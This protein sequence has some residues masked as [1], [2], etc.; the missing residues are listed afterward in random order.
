MSGSARVL[1]LPV[2]L[3]VV[4]LLAAL[5][6]G[7]WF[8]DRNDEHVAE[9]FDAV[10]ETVT[11]SLNERL[12]LYDYG[13]RGL[14]GAI[15]TAGPEIS[16]A[17]FE[18]YAATRDIPAEFPGVLGFGFV[19]RVLPDEMG[20]FIDAARAEGRPDFRVAQLL[21]HDGERFVI[22]YIEPLAGNATAI[23]LDIASENR[24]RQ[25][26]LTAM[27]TGKATLTPP[28]TLLQQGGMVPGFLLLLPVYRPGMATATPDQ[29]RQA[30]IGWAYAPLMID[31]VLADLA[32]VDPDIAFGIRDM[33]GDA[34]LPPFVTTAGFLTADGD[35]D[36]SPRVRRQIA[37][38]AFGRDWVLDIHPRPQF[39]DRLNLTKP[40]WAAGRA[41]VLGTLL[42]VLLYLHLVHLRRRER[43]AAEIR[44]LAESL[45]RQVAERTA[46]L[47]QREARFKALTELSADWYW[48]VNEAGRF[49]AISHGVMKLGLDPA[50]LIG[51]S[52]RDLAVD[53]DDPAID[54]YEAVLA[55]RLPFRDLAYDLADGAGESR[56]I[57][58][59]GE[60][61]FTED[62]IF[63]GFRG[64]GRDVTAEVDAKAALAAR[65]ALL[66]AVF[67]TVDQGIAVFGPDRRLLA[68]NARLAVLSTVPSELLTQ[69]IHLHD[70]LRRNARRGAYGPGDPDALVH[71]LIDGL[72]LDQPF[73]MERARA[74]GSVVDIRA[75]PMER[76]GFIATYADV[77]EARR[78][79]RDVTQA[80]DLLVSIMDVSLN[81]IVAFDAMRDAEGTIQDFRLVLMNRAAGDLIGVSADAIIGRCLVEA[82]PGFARRELFDRYRAV[83]ETGQPALF[84][85]HHD[86]DGRSLWL[87]VQA[88]PRAG[89]L[90][91]TFSD[92]TP[93]RE[94]EALLRASEARLQAIVGTIGI[95]VVVTAEDGRVS[96]VNRAA[97]Q[98]LGW[99]PGQLVG[100]DLGQMIR[101]APD[102]GPGAFSRFIRDTA[103]G[104]GS[105]TGEVTAIRRDGLALAVEMSVSAFMAGVEVMYVA[106]LADLSERNKAVVD[107]RQVNQQLE[108]QAAEL[109]ILA[110]E[111][112]RAR[113]VAETA[114]RA[115]SE[116]L[117][118]MSHEI[119]TPM[120][121][122]MGMTQILLG[123]P[124]TPDQRG[125][126]E[127]VR[128][129]AEALLGVIDDI[130]DVTKLEA[131]KVR[132][133]QVAFSLDDLIDGIVSILAP[134]TRDK[135]VQVACLVGHGASGTWLGDPTRLR[136]ILL[137]LAGNA[138]K[139][140]ERG[141]VAI[142]VAPAADGERLRFSIQD[143]GIGL[144]SV[145]IGGLFQKFAQADPSITR[146]FGGTGLGLA[147]SQQLVELMGG[148]IRVESEPGLGSTFWFEIALT[149]AGHAAPAPPS[150]AALRGLS[151]L[152][153][154]DVSVN[155]RVLAHHLDELGMTVET[156]ASAAESL[157]ALQMAAD[158]G[159]PVDLIVTDMGMRGMDG[160]ALASWVRSHPRF[161]SVRIVLAT[162]Y[163]IDA[164]AAAAFDAV[165]A[166]PVR[167]QALLDALGQAC[168]LAQ[169]DAAPVRRP[170]L[171]TPSDLV[172]P[173]DLATG[174]EVAGP[175]P[176][177]IG[178]HVLLVED[179]PTNQAVVT[180]LLEKEGYTVTIAGDGEQAVTA[181]ARMRFDLVLM[182][183]QMPVLDGLA[184]TRRIRDAETAA[185][186]PRVP[187]IAM[188]ANAMAGMRETYLEAGMDDY[189]PKPFRT[190]DL[191]AMA[192]RWSRR[193]RS[194]AATGTALSAP[195]A[196]DTGAAQG[197]GAAIA[198][199]PVL[200]DSTLGYLRTVVPKDRFDALVDEF[201]ALGLETMQQVG[202]ATTAGDMAA[203]GQL[204][205][206]IIST[207]GHCGLKQLSEAGRQL[208]VAVRA[209][210][211][212]EAHIA[213][214]AVMA[215]GP[216]S[217]EALRR[218]FQADRSPA[219][220]DVISPIAVDDDGTRGLATD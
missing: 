4:S 162:S 89:G 103:P 113:T 108:A 165:L 127:T 110:D 8:A 207:A 27:E 28:I 209:G 9:R 166:K 175:R 57:V 218:R 213:A 128:E 124:L 191:L 183:V 117:A 66:A 30:A 45:E 98:L 133:E 149:R 210:N 6:A 64:S 42:S 118:N 168:G 217:W 111:L 63:Q 23:G 208:Q 67:D 52:R 199:L 87:R 157:Q 21:A 88:V 85:H 176:S 59:S 79:E 73:T 193:R 154:D 148:T 178:R 121:G 141:Y 48:E 140:T 164:D 172:T 32:R 72:D 116:F 144:T 51:R 92:I 134:R 122:V 82:F 190:E 156:V 174:V 10:T 155:R 11:M 202:V 125:Y 195:D 54:A 38:A 26:A 123:T 74:D 212:A 179:N 112:D 131:G 188:T 39:V 205:H 68:W 56:H 130:L 20:V 70:I 96:M 31:A 18:R 90:V 17:S 150:D 184:A 126:A 2:G 152:V 61:V 58:I 94:R 201:I 185:Y 76:G 93:A 186:R 36:M 203:L 138:V 177:A 107:L 173:P 44:R 33:T 153:V 100:I 161:Q 43:A 135:A 104:H 132:L 84:D 41:M 158:Q 220:G 180:I 114:N 5:G 81:G 83:V 22:Q 78:R 99:P 189:M 146:R 197:G 215:A 86:Q 182:D 60:P 24:R 109:A 49:T 13:L 69:G 198:A 65:E 214:A 119:R 147:I 120:N 14:R 181:C 142:E 129:S 37:V 167:R 160:L 159:R 115:K 16:R 75:K 53:A 71:A 80:R 137:N 19:R 12:R 211:D 216:M 200:D 95:G 136:Q 187:I 163:P 219:A 35:V 29:R 145:Q 50:A 47:R 106:A 196:A 192:A 25:T 15:A 171:V 40:W 105:V 34:D 143:T 194:R 55:A 151:A 97:E 101:E 77:T 46:E 3:L 170:D 139:F 206:N 62:G 204:G 1:L 91:V 7:M 102:D 169:G